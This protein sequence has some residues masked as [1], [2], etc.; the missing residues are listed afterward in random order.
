LLTDQGFLIEQNESKPVDPPQEKISEYI[1]GK[2]LLPPG[3]PFAGP[4]QNSRTPYS[5]ELMDNM[6]PFSPVQYQSIMKAAQLGIT[7]AIEC[8][9]AYWMDEN[10]TEIMYVSA[11]EGLLIKWSEKRLEAL[12]DS[13]GF[14]HKIF[15]QTENKRSRRTGDKM[16]SKHFLGGALDMVT[17]RSGAGLRSETKR[18]AIVDEADGAP[19]IL[20]GDDG[21][22]LDSIHARTNA[23]GHKR[24]VTENS[25]P[26]TFEGLIHERFLLGDQRIFAV[27]CPL[28]GEL[29]PLEFDKI[30]PDTEGGLLHNVYYLCIKCNDAIFNHNKTSM[31][32][33]GFWDP[34]ATATMKHHRSYQMGAQYSPV[35]MFSWM[36]LYQK[37]LE[38]K[39]KPDGMKSF[40]N[41]YL[42][43]PYKETGARPDLEKTLKLVG[44]YDEKTIPDGVLWLTMAVDVQRGSETDV[45]NP[46]RLE[47]EILGM[48]AGYRSWS[49]LYKV[50]EGAVDDPFSGAWEDLA[51][52][53]EQG[54]AIYERSDGMEFVVQ[55][56]F[57]DSGD[58][59]N[60]DAVFR[61]CGRFDNI[62][63][64]K[65][66]GAIAKRKGEKGDEVGIHNFKRYRAQTTT[67]SGGALFYEVSTNYYKGHIYNNLKIERE[68]DP[69][70]KQRPGF[71]DFPRLRG[72]RYFE[73]L[74]A[75]ER[76]KD[77]SFYH[78]GRRNEA[79]DI[80]VYGICASD[81][82]LD[83]KV[84]EAKATA[85]SNGATPA[86]VQMINHKAVIE[87]IELNTARSITND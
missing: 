73:M 11:N 79:L 81:V 86:Q 33:G 47:L 20:P 69:T 29:Q 8:I 45:H 71:C 63:P 17:A 13:C 55:I 53:L 78:G 70:K 41:L 68:G 48:G 64:C 50:F 83:A 5:V 32:N 77:G 37:Y 52:W 19:K 44:A 10:P 26:T 35:G 56:G 31:L 9:I 57:V 21:P 16:F 74:T 2:R 82:W 76:R 43:L 40:T 58:G 65:G 3:T 84:L 54:G 87:R 42:G 67:R 25:T 80:R 30:H 28:C 22:Y 60:Y 39:E 61:W 85:K 46:A 24:K 36:E 6:S 23:W 18:L 27:P 4:W 51:D 66:F 59:E 15:A 34:Q 14:R 38:A 62:F 72:P 1:E 12:I 7:A 49:I 75:E